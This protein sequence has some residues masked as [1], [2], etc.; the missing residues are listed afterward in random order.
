MVGTD[1]TPSSSLQ[2][3][4][5]KNPSYKVQRSEG[6]VRT[7][8][9]QRSVAAGSAAEVDLAGVER[10]PCEFCGQLLPLMELVGHQVRSLAL[11]CCGDSEPGT[12]LAFVTQI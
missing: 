1:R 8:E 5:W 4:C 11:V 6:F 9:G 2:P 7:E 3:V 10:G 12:Q